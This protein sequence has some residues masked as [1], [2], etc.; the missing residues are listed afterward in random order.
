MQIREAGADDLG[1]ITAIYN[2]VLLSSAAIYSDTPA[3]LEDRTAWWLER[4]RLGY[5]CWSR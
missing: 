2:D 3:T 4:R 1:A 5:R